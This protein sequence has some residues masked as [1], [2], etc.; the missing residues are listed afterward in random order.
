MDVSKIRAEDYFIL[1]EEGQTKTELASTKPKD[2]V[3]PT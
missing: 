2:F 1:L 3:F